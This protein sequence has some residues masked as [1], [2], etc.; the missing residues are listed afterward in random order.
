MLLIPNE[1]NVPRA[2]LIGTLLI[3]LLI[4]LGLSAFFS[5]QQLAEGRAIQARAEQAADAQIRAHLTS[6]MES[7]VSFLEYTRSQT[8]AVLRRSLVEQ[9]ELGLPCFGHGSILIL[10]GFFLFRF[11]HFS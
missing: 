1:K 4:T 2:H 5:W 10:L 7:A 9:V 8:E 6:E 11:K 3:V